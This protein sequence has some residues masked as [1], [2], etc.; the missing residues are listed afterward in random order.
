MNIF[1]RIN[2]ISFI[3]NSLKTP[4][5][6]V[7]LLR[8]VLGILFIDTWVSNLEK[9]LYTP[10]GLES[11]LQ[12]QLNDDSLSWYRSFIEDV[13]IPSKAVFAPFQLVTELAMGVA[14]ILGLFTRP[15]SF[16]AFFFVLNT[17]L[18]SIGTGEWA[19]SYYTILAMLVI[20]FFTSAGRSIGLDTVL[21][22]RFGENKWGL[23]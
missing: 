5:F 23:W 19:W 16:G 22:K 15:V 2:D 6:W 1:N 10:D 12:G 4:L 11:F 14:L 17:Y 20:V 13:I 8:I 9:D 7:A 18:I 21:A 3:K